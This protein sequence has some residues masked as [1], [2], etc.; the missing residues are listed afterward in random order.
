MTGDC[1][2]DGSLSEGSLISDEFGV[3]FFDCCSCS[4]AGLN[5]MRLESIDSSGVSVLAGDMAEVPEFGAFR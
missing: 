4:I 2:S 3:T 1:F 5:Q